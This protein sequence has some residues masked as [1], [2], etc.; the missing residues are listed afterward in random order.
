MDLADWIG[1]AT[2]LSTAGLVAA[3]AYWQSR[4]PDVPAADAE[5]RVFA[6]S[7]DDRE[8]LERL[9]RAFG[10]VAFAGGDRRLLAELRDAVTSQRDV[11]LTIGRRLDLVID[12]LNE[13]RRA[14]ADNTRALGR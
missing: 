11:A 1:L 4:K 7:E 6:F 14:M 12:A 5:T 13:A 10:D 2:L 3:T 9:R 8:L